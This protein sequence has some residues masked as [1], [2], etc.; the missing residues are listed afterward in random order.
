MDKELSSHVQRSIS[1][2]PDTTSPTSANQDLGDTAIAS[3]TNNTGKNYTDSTA[4]SNSV[5]STTNLQIEYTAAT[6][7]LLRVAVNGFFDSLRV[8]IHAMQE[9]D[10]DTI[11]VPGTE[12]LEGVQGVE[13]G[14]V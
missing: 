7:R 12:T 1:V 14:S 9:L 3:N 10:T 8:V 11:D 2:L 6:N 13:M 4:S 5:S